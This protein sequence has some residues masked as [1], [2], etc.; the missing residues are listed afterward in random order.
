M[1]PT[2]SP[3]IPGWNLGRVLSNAQILEVISPD[4]EESYM[5]K[6]QVIPAEFLVPTHNVSTRE[7]QFVRY[8]HQ[9]MDGSWIVVD[10]SVEDVRSITGPSVRSVCRKHPSECLI[11]DLQNG[12]SHV[13]WVEHVDVREKELAPVFKSFVESGFAFGAKRWLSTLMLY[14]DQH[15]TERHNHHTRREKKPGCDGKQDGSQLLQRHQQFH[16]PS[17]D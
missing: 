4:I 7:V 6:K 15:F 8:S 9:Q 14:G 12:F 16:I 10:V 3:W 17:L 5:E 13:T 1:D 11:H 2:G